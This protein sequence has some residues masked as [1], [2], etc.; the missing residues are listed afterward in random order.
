MQCSLQANYAL[1]CSTRCAAESAE[2]LCSSRQP[3]GKEPCCCATLSSVCRSVFTICTICGRNCQLSHPYCVQVIGVC[4]RAN[5][6]LHVKRARFSALVHA[7][8]TRALN[9]L[10][11]STVSWSAAAGTF[12][13]SGLLRGASQPAATQA[14][15]IRLLIASQRQAF[16]SCTSFTRASESVRSALMRRSPV[17]LFTTSMALLHRASQAAD[18]QVAPNENDARAVDA[19]QEIDLR[20]GASFTR[21]QTLL[22]QA[23]PRYFIPLSLSSTS[24][25]ITTLPSLNVT[26]RCSALQS[27]C[28]S[29]RGDRP[30]HRRQL[31]ALPDPAAAGKALND[32]PASEQQACCN[33]PSSISDD[34][35]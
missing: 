2:N 35:S 4:C 26:P 19:R 14:M 22:L 23:R 20:I 9:N 28:D 13:A 24:A 7:D 30:A 33:S 29:T 10:V 17:H 18:V 31:H 32:S 5:P 12:A 27:L 34:S 1:A 8:V 15:W 21:F 11:R 6:Q 16:T 25:A 3:L